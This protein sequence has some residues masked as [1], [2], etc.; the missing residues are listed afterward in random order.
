MTTPYVGAF[1]GPVRAGP[2]VRAFVRY[3]KGGAARFDAA[4]FL[5]DASRS[6]IVDLAGWAWGEDYP[7]AVVASH[8]QD[9]P[10]YEAVAAVYKA[11]DGEFT[12]RVHGPDAMAWLDANRPEVSASVR[13]AGVGTAR[14]GAAPH[15]DADG[16]PAEGYATLAEHDA[17]PAP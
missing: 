9:L 16:T 11:M 10:G 5:A 15:W 17:T 3:A 12:C 7:A 8:V 13:R 14:D 1:T 6:D 2:V 4:P